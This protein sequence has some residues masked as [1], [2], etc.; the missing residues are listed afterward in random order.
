[1]AD[2][3]TVTKLPPCD[4]CKREHGREVPAEYDALTVGGQWGY[5]CGPC[6]VLCTLHNGRKLGTGIAQKLEVAA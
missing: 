2:T 4:E 6:F 5:L 3:A 1:M